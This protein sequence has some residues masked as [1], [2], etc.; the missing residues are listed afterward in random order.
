MPLIF[1]IAIALIGLAAPLLAQPSETPP[2]SERATELSVLV[3]AASSAGTGV[4]VEGIAGWELNK[5]AG[6]EARGGWFQRGRGA[7]AFSADVGA[8]LNVLAKRN[9]T[10]YVGAGIGLYRAW[11]DSVDAR[12]SSF[13]RRR[14]QAEG[15]G[16]LSFTDPA[17]RL[18]AGI[19]IITRRSVTIRP[20]ASSLVIWRDGRSDA[21]ALLGVRLGFRFE[22]Q[23]IT[24][25][26][27][28]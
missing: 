21:V 18:T 26:R 25:A 13:Y 20:E 24:P 3:G 16:D 5:W 22:D 11:F 4:A 1:V 8:T 14:L 15:A 12:M 28:R 6:V 9:V 7:D 17:L 23:V 19:D 10:P 27:G 2:D